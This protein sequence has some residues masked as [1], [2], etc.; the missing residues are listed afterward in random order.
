MLFRSSKIRLYIDQVLA[1]S[2]EAE[3][4]SFLERLDWL[5]APRRLHGAS[6]VKLT[7]AQQVAI[8]ELLELGFTSGFTGDFPGCT[9]KGD[10]HK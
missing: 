7:E 5:D 3:Q 6:F 4:K 9:H 2:G 1:A 10:T 8:L